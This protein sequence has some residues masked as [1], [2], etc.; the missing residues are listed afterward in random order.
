VRDTAVFSEYNLGNQRAKYMIRRGDWK[1]NYFTHDTPE[2]FN[3]RED[4]DE[5]HNLAGV[6][7]WASKMED[8][9]AQLLAWHRPPE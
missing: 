6:P 3:L 5:L 1:F 9:K 4:P 8:L 7:Q 2:L